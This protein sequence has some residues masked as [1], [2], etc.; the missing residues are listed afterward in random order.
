MDKNEIIKK[1]DGL[2]GAYLKKNNNLTM[3]E[4]KEV[5]KL[6]NVLSRNGEMKDIAV[7]LAR[8][9]GELTGL[10]FEGIIKSG[11]FSIK[12]ID[13]LLQS[14]Y[15][16]CDKEKKKQNVVNKY[17]NAVS[18]V[19]RNTSKDLSAS[20]VLPEYVGFIADYAVK[21]EKNQNRFQGLIGNTKGKIYQLD[22]SKEEQK[23]L[24]SI[25][26]VTCKIFPE[27]SN[28]AYCEMITAWAEK[29]GF[30]KKAEGSDIP[31]EK[32]IQPSEPLDDKN[33]TQE[34]PKQA[35]VPKMEEASA[36]VSEKK[37][38]EVCE[39][40]EASS[41][42]ESTMTKDEVVFAIDPEHLAE[43]TAE[44]TIAALSKE[45]QDFLSAVR[46]SA[47]NVI[48][49]IGE[50]IKAADSIKQKANQY[51]MLKTALTESEQ[52]LG[53]QKLLVSQMQSE[54]ASLKSENHELI[55]KNTVLEKNC[56]ELE[57]K[58]KNAYT[59]NSRESSLEAERIRNDLKKS[60]AF[61]YEDWLDY[62]FSDVSEENFESL[63]AIIKKVFRALERNGINYKESVK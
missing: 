43:M 42:A 38:K 12:T 28:K 2:Y 41:A 23:T 51:D 16:E 8:F 46:L 18:A 3:D 59:I 35:A 34:V 30:V 29:Y 9:S 56:S 17:I 21:S 4:K 39:K 25:W 37:N 36:V 53:E 49:V 48:K 63:Q 52:H 20:A 15:M 26:K 6:L 57:E 33:E 22:Y 60:F 7:Q 14:L 58:L 50:M 13:E 31:S 5:I 55:E 10:Y 19:L 54:L 27:I 24:E 61:L 32:E 45:N 44:K 1:L 47:D 62:E 40:P 11:I